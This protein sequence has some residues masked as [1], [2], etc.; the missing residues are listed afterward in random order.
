VVPAA[1]KYT[2]LEDGLAQPWA[3]FVWC[4]PPFSQATA[5]ADRFREHGDG[6]WL[7][8]V[9][10]SRW[11]IDLASAADLLYHLR[12]F[13]FMSPSHRGR[14]SSMPLAPGR[15]GR[16]G[17]RRPRTVRPLWPHPRRAAM[18]GRQYMIRA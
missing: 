15:P 6:L 16:P 14:Q 9:A 13:P 17:H 11:W 18:P 4:N 12:D 2:R 8:P 5:W 10:N 7:G 1:V 3:G